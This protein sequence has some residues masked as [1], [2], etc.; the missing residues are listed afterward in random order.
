[1]SEYVFDAA[2][3]RDH[4]VGAYTAYAGQL[5]DAAHEYHEA[6]ALVLLSTVTSDLR[7]RFKPFPKGLRT[8]LYVALLGSTSITRKSTAKDIGVDL[9][10]R[11]L[12]RALLSSKTTPEAFAE[13]LQDRPRQS[14]LWAVDEFAALL[15]QFQRR[16]YMTGLVDVLLELYNGVD[17]YTYSRTKKPVIIRSPHLSVIGCAADTVFDALH[18]HDIESGLLPRFAIVMPESKPSRLPF[19]ES[20]DEDTAARNNLVSQLNK[21]CP[22]RGE[23]GQVIGAPRE[24][25]FQ[26]Q[27]LDVIDQFAKEQEERHTGAMFRRLMP[28]VLKVA[29]L[30]AVGAFRLTIGN[31]IIVTAEDASAAITV[32]S[33]WT[34]FAGAFMERLSESKT[35]VLVRRASEFM[36]TRKNP[37]VARRAVARRLHVDS[38]LFADVERTLL[39]RELI[40]MVEHKAHAAGPTGGTKCWVWL[41]EKTDEEAVSA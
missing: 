8:N 31:D 29:V 28:M 10:T 2:F 19:F 5:T 40:K 4:F 23:D 35:E 3:P 6:V 21:L 36:R 32:V 9:L 12:P 25:R 11:V 38:R 24:V 15:V 7:A 33:R 17:E 16:D 39:D 1:M 34:R 18:L 41:E 27:T 30:S 13:Q 26:P 22:K 20:G 37:T 14:S